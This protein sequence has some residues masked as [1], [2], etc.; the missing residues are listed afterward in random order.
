MNVKIFANPQN[1]ALWDDNAGCGTAKTVL[2]G[3]RKE[4]QAQKGTRVKLDDYPFY[5]YSFT[6]S[7]KLWAIVL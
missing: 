1:F 5:A 2:Y 4:K 7:M 3:S 6:E